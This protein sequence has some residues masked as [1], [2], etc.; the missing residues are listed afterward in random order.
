LAESEGDCSNS[1]SS[2]HFCETTAAII[3]SENV[4]IVSL[5]E[6]MLAESEGVSSSN[7]Y[8][9]INQYLT[10]TVQGRNVTPH[11][12]TCKIHPVCTI[13]VTLFS[14]QA[15]GSKKGR[16][17]SASVSGIGWRFACS[18]GAINRY[19]FSISLPGLL[20]S[21]VGVFGVTTGFSFSR[22]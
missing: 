21:R 2:R 3:M 13:R 1:N 19:K 4:A 17:N 18:L 6:K 20:R 10:R 16:I 22:S 15:R 12:N 5:C 8:I 11:C 7:P 9:V 14:I